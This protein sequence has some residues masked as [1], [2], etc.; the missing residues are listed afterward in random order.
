MPMGELNAYPK[1]L[2]TSENMQKEWDTLDKESDLENIA[3]K[4]IVDNVFLYGHIEEIIMAYF[5]TVLYILK[6][7]K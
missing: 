5:I 3:S 7:D 6:I 2:T 1:F 4:I